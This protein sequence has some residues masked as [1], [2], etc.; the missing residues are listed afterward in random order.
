LISK[1]TFC[2]VP[3]GTVAHVVSAAE[4]KT[5]DL[6]SAAV[7]PNRL[8]AAGTAGNGIDQRISKGETLLY[9]PLKSRLHRFKVDYD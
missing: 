7:N 5:L 8:R 1:W 4:E 6:G 2:G 3:F 9:R